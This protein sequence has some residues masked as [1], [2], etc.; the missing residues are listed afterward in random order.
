MGLPAAGPSSGVP[1]LHVSSLWVPPMGMFGI[2]V[3]SLGVSGVRVSGLGGFCSALQVSVLWVL[4]VGVSMLSL[5]I[6]G[7]H[8]SA[9][10]MSGTSLS[11]FSLGWASDASRILQ[12]T[13]LLSLLWQGQ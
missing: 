4:S 1:A 8:D 6:W 9:T 12:V 13:T 10:M 2:G 5:L 3:H 11:P 7:Y